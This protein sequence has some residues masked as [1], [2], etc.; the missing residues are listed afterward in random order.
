LRRYIE[1]RTA[2]AAAATDL[3]A[4]LVRRCRLNPVEARVERD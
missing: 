3:A 1:A 4:A 2:A